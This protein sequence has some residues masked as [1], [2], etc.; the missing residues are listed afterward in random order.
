IVRQDI[1]AQLIES[2][3]AGRLHVV[4]TNELPTMTPG[5]RFHAHSLGETDVLLYARADL[6]RKLARDFP[7][8]LVGAPFVLPPSGAPLR[9]SLD[10]WLSE[11][12]LDIEV[13]AELDDAGLLRVFGSA[14]RGVFP[15]RAVLAA[16]VEDLRDVRLIGR[17]IG[18]REHYYAITSERRISHSALS[19]LVDSARAE[20]NTPVLKK[21]RSK[22]R[23]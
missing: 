22:R 5:T 23:R 9:R 19:A 7:R 12:R 20:L 2:L 4:L 14:G 1:A 3:A 11:Q 15:V 8:S 16:E 21:K 6:A 10:A 13:R 17:C 18:V